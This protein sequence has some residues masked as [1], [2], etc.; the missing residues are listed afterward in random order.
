MINIYY[1][2]F[3]YLFFLVVV[4]GV[5]CSSMYACTCIFFHVLTILF[6]GIMKSYRVFLPTE[7]STLPSRVI[8]RIF[9]RW[10]CNGCNRFE[11]WSKISKQTWIV[12]P[13]LKG[14]AARTLERIKCV[15]PNPDLVFCFLQYNMNHVIC[16]L[17]MQILKWYW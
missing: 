4:V 11:K 12:I 3:Y 10:N 15:V 17:K 8:W 13:W 16:S 5:N 14:V 7:M 9:M 1:P 2:T 6:E